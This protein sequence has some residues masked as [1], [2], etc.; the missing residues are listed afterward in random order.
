MPTIFS[1]SSTLKFGQISAPEY[2]TIFKNQVKKAYDKRMDEINNYLNIHED[3]VNMKTLVSDTN[4][5]IG[6]NRILAELT[7]IQTKISFYQ[8]ILNTTAATVAASETYYERNRGTAAAASDDK[9]IPYSPETISQTYTEA[10]REYNILTSAPQF[11]GN[12]T[13]KSHTFS[14]YD[15]KDIKD[16]YNETVRHKTELERQRDNLNKTTNLTIDLSEA[17]RNVCGL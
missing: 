7:N 17:S 14:L 15:E 1:F 13:D 5:K 6:L 8:T 3:L 10:V 4:A 16:I 12:L 2:A 11:D 9:K